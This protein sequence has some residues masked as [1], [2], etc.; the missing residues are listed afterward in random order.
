MAV[1]AV[2]LDV[3]GPLDT[4][5]ISEVEHSARLDVYDVVPV[6]RDAVLIAR[7]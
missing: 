7:T 2:L 1:R 5:M 6:M 4:E 3:G